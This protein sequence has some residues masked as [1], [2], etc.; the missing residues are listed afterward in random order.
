MRLE[1]IFLL[2]YFFCFHTFLNTYEEN[3]CEQILN[4]MLLLT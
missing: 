3:G 2:F 4:K 1:S